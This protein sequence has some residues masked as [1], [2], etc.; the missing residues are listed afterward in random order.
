MKN[1]LLVIGLIL[2]FLFVSCGSDCEFIGIATDDLPDA[3]VGKEY[4]V[5]IEHNSTCSPA[6]KLVQI[7]EGSLP[8]GL[9]FNGN[10]TISGIPTEVIE[11]EF[12][13]MYRVCFGTGSFGPTGC[14]DKYKT[15]TITVKP[16]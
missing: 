2:G 13:I 15:F 9:D 14:T 6:S 8:A 10:G 11:A 3:V 7:T 16:E 4:H 1:F 5:V 12:E